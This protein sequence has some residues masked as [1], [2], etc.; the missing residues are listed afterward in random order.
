MLKTV[1][2]DGEKNADAA[3]HLTNIE[4]TPLLPFVSPSL[5]YLQIWHKINI[6]YSIR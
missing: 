5:S 2:K 6:N 1:L 3:V 4:S